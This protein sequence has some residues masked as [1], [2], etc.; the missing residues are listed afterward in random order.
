[1]R[2]ASDKDIHSIIIENDVGLVT[3]EMRDIIAQ[4][5]ADHDA[6]RPKEPVQ[7]DSGQFKI[8]KRRHDSDTFSSSNSLTRKPMSQGPVSNVRQ[9]FSGRKLNYLDYPFRAG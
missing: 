1:M 8:E 9:D 7:K 5:L 3:K 2:D 4:V 6:R